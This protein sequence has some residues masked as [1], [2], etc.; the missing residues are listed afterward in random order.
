MNPTKKIVFK[1]FLFVFPL[2]ILFGY[3]EYNLRT[4]HFA[5][6]YAAKKYYFEQQIE[7]VETLV[8]GS[9]QTFNGINPS[10]FTSKTF[11]LA[12]VSQTLYYDKRL[13][14]Q[15]LPKL[16]KLKTVFISIGYYSFFYQ[17]CD[18]TESWR[19][20]FYDAHFNIAGKSAANSSL[21]F[22][23]TY[24]PK[25][26]VQLLFNNFKDESAIAIYTNGYQ[27]KYQQKIINDLVGLE[28]VTVHDAENF[29]NRKADIES[30]LENFVQILSSK[31]IKII[32]LTM[33]VFS[34]YSKYCSKNI[35]EQNTSFVNLLCKKYNCKYLNYFTDERFV[36]EDFEDNDHLKN[37]GANKLSYLINDTLKKIHN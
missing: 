15:Y 14:L 21:L 10:C 1:I 17:M 16:K 34:S 36:K 28:R 13:T 22:I 26:C 5:S 7:S 4:K 29:V 30:D 18:I 19:E 23:N 31:R 12:N 9:S 8:L 11:N 33:P 35:I 20:G 6:S 37:N 25:H 32:F 2:L 24:Q 27:P 3:I